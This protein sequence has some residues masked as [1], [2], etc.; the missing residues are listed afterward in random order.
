MRSSPSV[1]V[2]KV[3]FNTQCQESKVSARQTQMKIMASEQSAMSETI[4]KAVAEATRVALQ[5]MAAAAVNRPHTMAGSK[6]G[7]SAMKQPTFKLG[8]GR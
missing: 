7:G 5:T 3:W 8:N 6:T 2:I 4:A 1:I